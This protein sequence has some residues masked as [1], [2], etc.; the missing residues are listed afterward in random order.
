M[1]RTSHLRRLLPAA[2]C[3]AF[4]GC[5]ERDTVADDAS[6]AGFDTEDDTSPAGSDTEGDGAEPVS[7]SGF[8]L[9]PPPNP[10]ADDPGA[11]QFFARANH[12]ADGE[13]W[14]VDE[15]SEGAIKLDFKVM[16]WDGNDWSRC[17]GLAPCDTNEGQLTWGMPI[18]S[19]A[20]GEITACARNFPDNP[21]PGEK[22]D[23]VNQPG[24][25]DDDTATIHGAGNNVW[26]KTTGGDMIA[27]THMQKGSILPEVCPIE[28]DAIDVATK[29]GSYNADLYIEPGDRPKVKRGQLIGLAGNSGNSTAP[30]LHLQFNEPGVADNEV[31]AGKE[32]TFKQVYGQDLDANAGESQGE[33]YPFRARTLTDADGPTM[34]HPAPVLRRS[35]AT[36]GSISEVDTVFLDDSLAVTAERNADGKLQLTSWDVRWDGIDRLGDWYDD[37]GTIFRVAKVDTDKLLVAR[38]N[39]ATQ[40]QLTLFQVSAAGTFDSLYTYTAGKI[41]AL[42]LTGYG[43]DG[44]F[45]TAVRDGKGL[46]KLIDWSVEFSTGVG[47]WAIVRNGSVGGERVAAVAITQS[48]GWDGVGVAVQTAD[49]KLRTI[50]F[51]ISN[52]GWTFARGD[53]HTTEHDTSAQIDITGLTR[54]FAAATQDAEG[55]FKLV[56]YGATPGGDL[57]GV[58]SSY[59]AG[60]VSRVDITSTP[61][62]GNDVISTVRD[63]E[64]NMLLMSFA[65]T[66]SGAEIRRGGTE[67]AGEVSVIAT[68][69]TQ[70]VAGGGADRDMF[71]TAVRN[72]V[73]NLK[74]IYWDVNL[75]D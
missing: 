27:L 18:Y 68:A 62:A 73:G 37:E 4:P 41:T 64:G 47:D 72:S 40:L 57:V 36:I 58:S 15:F 55:R 33:W 59:F 28:T 54:G 21:E 43:D 32:V 2:L 75:S 39:A 16:F 17:N 45:V 35:E 19:P 10:S 30:H 14:V 38:R 24:A 67:D 1:T 7:N 12:L 26:I 52:S 69:A 48:K 71:L 6:E 11:Y 66:E 51:T 65:M 46:L 63:G 13:F 56:T 49:K 23:A 20:D 8:D 29:N 44:H 3:L 42:D 70:R 34:V 5:D 60:Q 61:D 53:D 31:N 22:L 50:P 25:D 74:L 9:V